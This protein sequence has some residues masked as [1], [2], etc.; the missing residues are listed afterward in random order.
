MHFI[1]QM[2]GSLT[3]RSAAK[4]AGLLSQPNRSAVTF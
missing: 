3:E 1:Y 4:G 2:S